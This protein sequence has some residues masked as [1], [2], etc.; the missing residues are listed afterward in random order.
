VSPGVQNYS[1]VAERG[2]ERDRIS[3][4]QFLRTTST[5]TAVT[6]LA[7]QGILRFPEA[8]ASVTPIRRSSVAVNPAQ[9]VGVNNLNL[10]VML[11]YEST[12]FTKDAARRQL[13]RNAGF[14]LVRV[15]D[16]QK[17]DPT[18]CTSW[19]ETSGTGTFDWTDLDAL[20]R[21]ITD[22]GAEPMFCLGGTASSVPSYQPKIPN[23]M[24]VDPSTNLPYPKSFAAYA[25]AW[26]KHFKSEGLPVRFYEVWNE[27]WGY[28]GWQPVDF[29]KL[30]NYMQLFNATAAN[31]RGENPDIS[32]SFDFITRQPVLDYWLAND[33]ADVD[34]LNF[35][36]YG[37]YVAGR[38][39]DA[40]MFDKAENQYFGKWPMGY[41][42]QEARQAWSRIHGRDLPVIC[43]ESGFN[44]AWENGTDPRIQQMAGTVWNALTL[45][46]GILN[47]L[48]Y[49]VQYCLSMSASYGATQ[50]TGGLGFGMI[51]RDNNAP[52]Y[53]YHLHYMLGN[54]LSA[55]DPLLQTASSSDNI[56][57]LA[58]LH[59]GI[60]RILLICKNDKPETITLQ[61]V[62]GKAGFLRIDNNIPWIQ[63]KLQSGET[64][65]EE[66][67]TLNGY[68]VMLLGGDDP[69]GLAIA[70]G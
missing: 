25:G 4:R 33:G 5:L 34:S 64:N 13:V 43:S 26:V 7:S 49:S 28:F 65:L 21:S 14:K 52:W 38:L 53:P 42:I 61:G 39:T 56:R 70:T 46:M 22:T 60:L 32:I 41:T 3:R 68:T 37:D 40:E 12:E 35:H 1:R 47:G 30:A 63:P 45:R 57:T 18:P 58:W 6:I 36:K 31:M 59:N 27:P 69:A 8:V 24:A 9:V 17:R 19:D 20:V 2:R 62:T 44:S 67:L 51:N 55:G 23:G 29:G 16:N 10:G 15:F 54:N 50:Q 48:M 11:A 66:P